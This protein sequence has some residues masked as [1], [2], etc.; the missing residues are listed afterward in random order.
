MQR[1]VGVS[2]ANTDPSYGQIRRVSHHSDYSAG[3]GIRQQGCAISAKNWAGMFPL[4]VSVF[5]CQ[6]VGFLLFHTTQLRRIS[7]AVLL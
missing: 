7:T 1:T 6:S 4:S 5:V 2:Y 3:L